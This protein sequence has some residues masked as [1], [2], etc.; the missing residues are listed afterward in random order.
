MAN[1][2]RAGS[3]HLAVAVS[4]HL[5]AVTADV[6]RAFRDAGVRSIL[7]RGPAVGS[8]LYPDENVRSYVD[9]D[10]LVEETSAGKASSCLEELGFEDVSVEGVLRGDRPTH[11]HTWSRADRALVDLHTTIVGVRIPAGE[12]WAV[13]AADTATIAVAGAEVEILHESARAL[14]LALHAAQHGARFTPTLD[15]LERAFARLPLVTWRQASSL[16]QRLDAVDAFAAGLRLLPA[17]AEVANR[18]EL[19]SA[20]AVDVALRVGTPPPMALGFEWLSQTQSWRGRASLAARKIAPTPAFMRAWSPLARRGRAGLALAY[21]WRP[22][23][24]VLHAGPAF[25]AWRRA[26]SAAADDDR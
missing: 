21:L 14:M 19:P 8:W 13:L 15:D 5:D 16:A 20:T 26:R 2:S 3:K 4:L 18:L 25:L 23:W 1:E 7:L 12:A 9:V 24:I 6:V 17:G 11:A 10:L 22:I